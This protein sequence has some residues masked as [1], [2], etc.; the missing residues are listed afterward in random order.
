MRRGASKVLVGV[1]L[2]LM[3]FDVVGLA[4]VFFPPST[5]GRNSSSGGLNSTPQNASLTSA[6]GLK[7]SVT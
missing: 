5:S 7:L 2:V 3:L 4:F 1:A 6:L